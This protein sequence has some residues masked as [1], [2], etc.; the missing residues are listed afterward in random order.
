MATYGRVSSSTVT[1]LPAVVGTVI[2]EW[3][4]DTPVL[5]PSPNLNLCEHPLHLMRAKCLQ[6]KQ[7]VKSLPDL[8]LLFVTFTPE[9]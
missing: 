2:G 4:L 9:V 6:I 8:L 1:G 3:P 5:K 7:D